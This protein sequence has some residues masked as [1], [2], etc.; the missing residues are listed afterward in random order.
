MQEM[1]ECDQSCHLLRDEINQ[2]QT[3]EMRLKTDAVCALSQT[4]VLDAKEPFYIFPSGYVCLESALKQEVFPR[5][6]TK[7]R[8]HAA[9]IEKQLQSLRMQIESGQALDASTR[10][11]FEQ[12][13]AELNGL[14]A[15]E[16]PLTGRL[17]V[18]GLDAVFAMENE[19]VL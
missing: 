17:M 6:S 12:L 19:D 16:C 14:I 3:H 9:D 8:D 4:R 18:D 5:L 15:A 10:D 13:Q 1:K 7:Q 2:L 11:H